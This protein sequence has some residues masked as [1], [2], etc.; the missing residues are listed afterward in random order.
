VTALGI[1]YYELVQVCIGELSRDRMKNVALISLLLLGIVS[2]CSS[3]RSPKIIQLTEPLFPQYPPIADANPQIRQKQTFL[4][5]GKLLVIRSEE[6][7]SV[8]IDTSSFEEIE[9]EIGYKMVTGCRNQV[10]VTSD[11]ERASYA[12]GEVSGTTVAF[13]TY[14]MSR[15]LHGIPV[16]GKKYIVEVRFT[17]FETDIP[18]QH[19]WNPR[20]E[21]YKELWTRTLMSSEI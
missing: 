21:K 1:E 15:K 9:L 19:M 6:S 17:I 4:V 7:I 20:S 18:S 14:I 12:Y 8:S 3:K 2:G 10:F 11:G 16:L 13:G 5:P